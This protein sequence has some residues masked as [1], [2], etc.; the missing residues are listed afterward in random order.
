M[1]TSATTEWRDHLVLTRELSTPGA[2]AA[3]FARVR[4]GEFVAVSRGS[5]MPAEVWAG[6]DGDAQYR[7]V[8]HIVAELSGGSAFSHHSAAVLWRLPVVGAWPRR[9]HILVE[10]AEGGRSSSAIFRHTVG[11]PSDL[12]SIDGLSVTSLARTVV[13]LARVEPFGQAVVFADAALRRTAHPH[14]DVPR[15]ALGKADLERELAQVPLRQGTAKIRE[16]ITFADGAADR[17]GESL[18]RTS[19]LRAGVSMPLLQVPLFGAS[20]ARYQVD[21][22]WPVFDVIGEFDGQGKYVLP[23]FL[24][25]RT[26]EQALR[27]EKF[28]EDDLRAAGHGMTR[29]GWN[30]AVSP[31]RLAAHLAVAGVK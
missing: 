16:V 4:N 21:F 2:R 27:D 23:Q 5:Y 19:M 31:R 8:L 12:Q 30:V 26:P 13:D 20:G 3:F 14:P 15:T 25:G 29:W 9:A 28:R 22:W 18:S 7:I 11:V 17:P 1:L 24:R 6:L 10:E